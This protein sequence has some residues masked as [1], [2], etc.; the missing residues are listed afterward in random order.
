MRSQE[1]LDLNKVPFHARALYHHVK[2][3]GQPEIGGQLSQ[4]E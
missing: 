4:T 1:N 3:Q 2:L